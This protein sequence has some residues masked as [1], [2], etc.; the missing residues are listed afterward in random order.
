MALRLGSTVYV[1]DWIYENRVNTLCQITHMHFEFMT[2][3]GLKIT[4]NYGKRLEKKKFDV[5]FNLYIVCI[6]SL[7]KTLFS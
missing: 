2:P 5:P 6:S 4:S 3:K 7:A 1:H